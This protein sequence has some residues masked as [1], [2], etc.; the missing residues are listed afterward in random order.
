M[1]AMISVPKIQG[2]GMDEIE[3]IFSR[4]YHFTHLSPVSGQF[5]TCSLQKRVYIQVLK[6]T[7]RLKSNILPKAEI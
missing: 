3:L 6:A 1:N 4:K 2:L 5:K 7:F